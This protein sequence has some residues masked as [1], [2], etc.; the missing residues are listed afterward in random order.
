[1]NLK[2]KLLTHGYDHIDILLVD[3]EANQT[4]VPDITLHKVTDLEYKLYLDPETI[5]YHL[6]EEDPYFEAEQSDEEGE[7]KKVKGFVLEW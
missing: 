1:M 2:D 4:T 5:T 3:E 7:S 6:N